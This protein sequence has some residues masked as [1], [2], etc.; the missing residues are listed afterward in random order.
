MNRFPAEIQ[1]FGESFVDM[2]AHRHISDYDP[3]PEYVFTRSRVLQTIQEAEEAIT[4]FENVPASDRR[5]FAIYVL[6]R[7]RSG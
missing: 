2:Q 4:D 1:N 5:A 3:D 7:L 6:L